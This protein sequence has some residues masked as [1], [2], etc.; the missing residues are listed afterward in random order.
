[1]L[2]GAHGGPVTPN[3]I[4]VHRFW[5]VADS[6]EAVYGWITAH[7]PAG[8]Q[9][10]GTG[11]YDGPNG[12]DQSVTFTRASTNPGVE[13]EALQ[14]TV[15]AARGG[16]AAIRADGQAVWIVPRPRSDLIPAGVSRVEVHVDR[17]TTPNVGYLVKTFAQ[18]A[19]VAKLVRKINSLQNVQP[20]TFTSCPF[21]GSEVVPVIDLRFDD[22]R[23]ALTARAVENG[24]YGLT[25]YLDGRRQRLALQESV[26]LTRVLWRMRAFATCTAKHLRPLIT[27]GAQFGAQVSFENAS[28]A[29]CG[30]DEFVQIRMRTAAQRAI[31]THVTDAKPFGTPLLLFPGAVARYAL[32]WQSEPPACPQQPEAAILAARLAGIGSFTVRASPPIA[33]CNGAIEESAP[34]Y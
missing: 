29:V 20:G 9:K 17:A 14:V 12:S 32:R 2:A 5:R 30:L 34:Y 28:Q 19:A 21:G 24:C 22:A 11:S 26:N 6:P 4:D 18:P 31:P 33:P 10:N 7:P 15:A 8:T 3:L 16:G 13:E 1:M 23:G 27:R 25:F